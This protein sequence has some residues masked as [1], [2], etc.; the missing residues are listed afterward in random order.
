MEPEVRR[1]AIRFAARRASLNDTGGRMLTERVVVGIDFGS[2]A[3]DAAEWIA[4]EFA[5]DAEL[6]LVHV[7]ERPR[8][9]GFLNRSAEAAEDAIETARSSVGP[10]LHRLA[11]FLSPQRPRSLVRFG[12]PH[13]EL[14][15]VAAEV[16]ADLIVVGAH[17]DRP[18]PW[19]TLGTTA[20]R[21]VRGSPI[22]V[23]IPIQSR[24]RPPRSVLAAVDDADITPTVLRWAKRIA[25]EFSAAMSL[26][27]VVSDAAIARMV[28]VVP[29][30]LREDMLTVRSVKTEIVGA[31]RAW[32]Q[33][34]ATSHLG[35]QRAETIVAYGKAGDAIIESAKAIDADIVVMGRRGSGLVAPA[36]LGSTV[37]TVLHGAPCPVFVVTEESPS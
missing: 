15:Q 1:A 20:E 13:D 31:G 21:I 11:S 23:L 22:P 3:K 4:R 8:I 24:R 6:V 29:A 16:R 25:S 12:R 5:P 36:L 18:R 35:N 26:M 32:L 33:D 34:L 17:G 2:P 10:P 28:T 9:P 27:H 14:L 37:R 30:A 19:I 7:I